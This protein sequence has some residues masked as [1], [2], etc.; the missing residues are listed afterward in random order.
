MQAITLY[1]TETEEI[2]GQITPI[3]K[4]DFIPFYYMLTYSQG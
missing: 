2:I 4:I 1:D 3:E